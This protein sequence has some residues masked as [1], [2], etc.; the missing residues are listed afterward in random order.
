MAKKAVSPEFT[1]DDSTES[2]IEWGQRNARALA[3]G[4]ITVV[5]V[6]AIGLFA[7]SASAR[8]EA[9]AGRDLAAAQRA[10]V[11]GNAALA[12]SDLQRLVQRYDGTKAAIQARMLLAQVMFDQG[13][14]DSG[15]AVL[16]D[17]DSPGP[18]AASYHAI[19]A[20]GLEQSGKLTEAAAAY[21]RASETAISKPD[22]AAHRADAARVYQAAGNVEEAKGIWTDLAADDAGPMAGEAKVRLGE[23][24]A[25]PVTKS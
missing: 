15:L 18:F 16:R 22:R 25:Q 14:A 2:L 12:Q 4:A 17:I 9:N 11:S 5:V 7:R 20:A 13:K 23:L 24:N 10:V 19:M 1:L 3:I 21:L 8:K 6:L